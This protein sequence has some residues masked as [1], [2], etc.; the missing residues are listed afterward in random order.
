MDVDRSK[1]DHNGAIRGILTEEL[2][3]I[4]GGLI[5]VDPP[6]FIRPYPFRPPP[7]IIPPPAPPPSSPL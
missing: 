6:I 1:P 3:R 7:G 5:P 4:S 2:D